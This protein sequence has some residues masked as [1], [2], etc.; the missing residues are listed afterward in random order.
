MVNKNIQRA[1][2]RITRVRAKIFGTKERPRVSV[3]RTNKYLYAQ[4]I[5]DTTAKTIVSSSSFAAK[6]KGTKMNQAKEV[7]KQL[8]ELLKKNKIKAVVFDR[9]SF[10]YN[11]RV[12]AFAESLR[13]NQIVV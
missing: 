6:T 9:G 11:G 2:R 8:A 10:S 5:D 12:K 4:V 3:H 7:G 1:N 13:E